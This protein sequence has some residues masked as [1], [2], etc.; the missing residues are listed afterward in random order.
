MSV[1][2]LGTACRTVSPPDYDIPQLIVDIPERPILSHTD[3]AGNV[4][5]LIAYAESLEHIVWQYQEYL[6]RLSAIL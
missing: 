5:S 3:M 1:L 2:I 4:S 6:D